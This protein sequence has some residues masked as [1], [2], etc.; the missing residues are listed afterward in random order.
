MEANRELFESTSLLVLYELG[1][2]NKLSAYKI[3]GHH[4]ISKDELK[5]LDYPNKKPR[6]SYMAFDIVP[7][8]KDLTF[9]V[10]HHLVERLIELNS[11]NAKGTPVFIQP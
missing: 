7:L 3:T 2:P 11:E 10:E 9:L 5:K 4:V 8:E 6:K 1:K